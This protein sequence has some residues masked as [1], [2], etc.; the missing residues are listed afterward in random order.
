MLSKTVES[1]EMTEIAKLAIT[2]LSSKMGSAS[3]STNSVIPGISRLPNVW[4]AMM[5]STWMQELAFSTNNLQDQTA[6]LE[7]SR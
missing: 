4:H 1:M 7:V 3:K 6:L 5:D 2:D